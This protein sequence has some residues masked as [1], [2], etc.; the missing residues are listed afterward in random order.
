MIAGVL[1]IV[2][3]VLGGLFILYQVVK[4]DKNETEKFK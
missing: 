3:Y 1:L 4:E 2:A